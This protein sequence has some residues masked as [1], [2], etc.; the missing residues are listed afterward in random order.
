MYD[1]KEVIAANTVDDVVDYVKVME[2]LDNDYVNPIV[3]K[4]TDK[5]KLSTEAVSNLVKELGLDG[6]ESTEG[7]KLYMKTLGGSTDEAKEANILLDIKLKELQGK[8]DGEV[9]IR[10]NQE[11]VTKTANERDAIKALGIEDKDSIDFLHFKLSKLVTDDKD[12]TTVVAE[13]AKDKDV[14]TTTRFIK[15]DFGSTS[16]NVDVGAAWKAK[17]ESR[18]RK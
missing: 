6:V 2:L 13:Y 12:F 1:L 3:A 17:R 15:D 8:Y 14:K 11:K 10:T 4:K 18:G 7:L 9:E 16:N 5:E